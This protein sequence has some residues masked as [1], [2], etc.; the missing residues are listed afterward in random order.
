M[1]VCVCGVF[2]LT[3]VNVYNVHLCEC[4]MLLVAFPSSPCTRGVLVG[5]PLGK[6]SQ[7]DSS[8]LAHLVS[9]S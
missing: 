4:L 6:Q 8:P 7:L 3:Q 9:R 1:C 5:F 2:L